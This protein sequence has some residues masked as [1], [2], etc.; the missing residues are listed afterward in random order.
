[1]KL[2]LLKKKSRRKVEKKSDK[3]NCILQNVNY[4]KLSNYKQCQ[5]TT[6]RKEITNRV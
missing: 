3:W 5:T 4:S 6:I 2:L 1:M